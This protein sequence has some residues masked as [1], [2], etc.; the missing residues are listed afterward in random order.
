MFKEE[1][2]TSYVGFKKDGAQWLVDNTDIK[3][4][5]VDYLSVAAYD[6]KAG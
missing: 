3:L 6:E 4:V 5:G 2:D 1:F